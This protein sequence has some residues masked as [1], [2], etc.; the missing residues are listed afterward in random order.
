MP[1]ISVIKGEQGASESFLVFALNTDSL[2]TDNLPWVSTW[3][4]EKGEKGLETQKVTQMP[5]DNKHFRNTACLE[6]I[7]EV[8][9]PQ[10]VFGEPWIDQNDI[11]SGMQSRRYREW[12]G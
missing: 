4:E 12:N 6:K 1:S 3:F 11:I 8:R 10:H 9:G 2:T 5:P 7:P